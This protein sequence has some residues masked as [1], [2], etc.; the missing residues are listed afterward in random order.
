[1][2]NPWPSS[3]DSAEIACWTKVMSP[4]TP[5]LSAFARDAEIAPASRSA[6]VIEIGDAASSPARA[7]SSN[8]FIIASFAVGHR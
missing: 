6:P 7:S 2:T 8:V 4:A 1:M 5:A 3:A